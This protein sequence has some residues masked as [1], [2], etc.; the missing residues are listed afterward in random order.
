MTDLELEARRYGRDLAL[1]SGPVRPTA[2][3]DWPVLE[4]RPCLVAGLLDRAATSPGELVHRPQYGAG[5]TEF[6]ESI[7]TPAKQAELV[8]RIRLNLIRDGR[9][10]E[11]AVRI[12][13]PVPGRSEVTILFRTRGARDELPSR[14]TFTLQ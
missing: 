9:L 10:S 1:P 13:M 11:V 6:V 7:G 3:G 5:A 2:S 4:G 12:A 8:G 14:A